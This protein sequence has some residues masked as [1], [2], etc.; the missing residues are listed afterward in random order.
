LA[1][2]AISREKASLPAKLAFSLDGKKTS[3]RSTGFRFPAR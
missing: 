2:R 1:K 3:D